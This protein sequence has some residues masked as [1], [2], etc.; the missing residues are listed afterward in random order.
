MTLSDAIKQCEDEYDEEVNGLDGNDS[1]FEA[2]VVSEQSEINRSGS[3]SS[4]I[5]KSGIID[6]ILATMCAEGSGD[7]RLLAIIMFRMGMRVQ[8]KLLNPTQ[9]TTIYNGVQ[10]Q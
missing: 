4:C 2:L 5:V 8:R 10:N 3:F 1:V 7:I 9:K 6:N